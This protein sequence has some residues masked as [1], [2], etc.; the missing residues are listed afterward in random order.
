MGLESTLP[1]LL[2][3]AWVVPLGSYV[4]ILFFGPRMGPHGRNAAWV[5]TAA[6]VT[7]LVL[8]LTAFFVWIGA[9]PVTASHHGGHGEHAIVEP[10]AGTAGQQRHLPRVEVV[11]DTVFGGGVVPLSGLQPV[12]TEPRGFTQRRDEDLRRQRGDA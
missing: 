12:L 11:P 2:G 7:S 8:S 3:L 4:A 9:H 6:I 1:M 10:A 5:A